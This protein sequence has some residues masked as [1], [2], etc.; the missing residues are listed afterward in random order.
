MTGAQNEGEKHP[1]VTTNMDSQ[2]A[3]KNSRRHETSTNHLLPYQRRRLG[4]RI[5]P[6]T[7]K[8][9]TNFYSHKILLKATANI[10][11]RLL[12]QLIV[13]PDQRELQ[14][15]QFLAFPAWFNQKVE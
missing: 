3:P 10:F 12:E 11:Q 13:V 6:S 7:P 1:K 14:K 5:R 4:K 2:S 8:D 15:R 9:P